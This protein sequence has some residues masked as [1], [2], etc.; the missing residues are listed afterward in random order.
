[1]IAVADG[2]LADAGVTVPRD[3]HLLIG[4]G[5]GAQWLLDN[6][7]V[8]EPVGYLSRNLFQP[9]L[10]ASSERVGAF[11]NPALPA[12]RKYALS[13]VREL[14]DNYAV[15]GIVFDR[16][17]FASLRT[18]FSDYS[19]QAFE[20]FLGE[21]LKAFPD[22]IYS[23]PANPGEALIPGRFFQQWLYWRDKLIHDWLQQARTLAETVRPGIKV[24]A[25]V[26]SWYDQYYGVGVNWGS[27]DFQADYQWTPPNYHQTGYA[28]LLD[29]I[30][31]GC[32]YQLA[33]RAEARELGEPEART[34]EA[35]A[36]LSMEAVDAGTF[37][38]AGIYVLDYKHHPE[39]FRQ[40]LRAALRHSQGIMLFDLVYVEE[41]DWWDLIQQALA[42]PKP[43]PHDRGGLQRAVQEVKHTL[44]A[45][46]SPASR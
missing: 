32:Y 20:Q 13:V 31:T 24:G 10:E 39:A 18:D 22:D 25:Y 42:E 16:M 9:I 46:G 5:T 7:E 4:R 8:G 43:A 1:V 37:V 26:G 3:G 40:A 15:D 14:V 6:L 35:A 17:R 41:Y 11:V 27:S 28:E 2:S 23:W 34:V 38:Y 36:Q 12:A 19:R 45:A 30:S 33:T 21:K 44:E 29:W